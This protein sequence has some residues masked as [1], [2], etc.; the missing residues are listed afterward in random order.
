MPPLSETRSTSFDILSH[1]QQ[2]HGNLT[3]T[4]HT[5]H[6]IYTTHYRG[7]HNSR[8][9]TMVDNAR[10]EHDP[11][12]V[13]EH[14]HGCDSCHG[15]STEHTSYANAT[16]QAKQDASDRVP[17]NKQSIQSSDFPLMGA[18]WP[19]ACG[20]SLPLS[21]SRSML[22]I[23]GCSTRLPVPLHPCSHPP[24]SSPCTLLCVLSE[25]AM[26]G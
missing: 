26:R 20:G 13:V 24:D 23:S 2:K 16:R 11:T 18:N 6:R 9:H 5:F 3:D 25:S 15:K 1:L 19:W 8:Y 14:L 4:R 12:R 22:H 7:P 10:P 17:N 21:T